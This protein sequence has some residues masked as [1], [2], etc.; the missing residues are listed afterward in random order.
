MARSVTSFTLALP[1]LIDDVRFLKFHCPEPVLA[2]RSLCVKRGGKPF[3]HLGRAGS[4]AKTRP[5]NTQMFE[6]F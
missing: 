1:A 3:S 5:K 2:K 4:L 6:S